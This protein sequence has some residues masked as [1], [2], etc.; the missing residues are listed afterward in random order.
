MMALDDQ[1]KV[2]VWGHRQALIGKPVHVVF[3]FVILGPIWNEVG[4]RKFRSRLTI[5]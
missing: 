1:G 5:T 3:F 4:F 2:Y